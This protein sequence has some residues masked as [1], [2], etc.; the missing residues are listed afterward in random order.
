MNN[1]K[2]KWSIIFQ[3]YKVTYVLCTKSYE[4]HCK[5]SHLFPDGAPS[6]DIILTIDLMDSKFVMFFG[7]HF[8]FMAPAYRALGLAFHMQMRAQL[9]D[10]YGFICIQ[11]HM[12]AIK[13]F[14]MFLHA[15]ESSTIIMMYMFVN[16]MYLFAFKH[17]CTQ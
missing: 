11:T 12:Q 15:N 7:W 4:V 3:I 8:I 10:W 14:N 1:F 2:T 6:L 16:N 17:T 5:R 9:C 13:K